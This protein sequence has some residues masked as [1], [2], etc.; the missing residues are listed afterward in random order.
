VP[1]NVASTR[2]EV[3]T[4]SPNG[5]RRAQREK[6]WLTGREA[7]NAGGSS[8]AGILI[9]GFT[10]FRLTH[11]W[12]GLI[13]ALPRP[14][15]RKQAGREIA[16]RGD[17]RVI[18]MVIT[19]ATTMLCAI[20]QRTPTRAAPRRPRDRARDVSVVETGMPSHVA[21]NSVSAAAVSAQK[22]CIGLRG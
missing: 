7:A 21:P 12:R 20:P 3:E 17:R 8:R 9:A 1:V 13:R 2:L 4:E 19:Q 6:Q 18:G 11:P 5:E 16:E 15:L 14:G 22:P 10:A